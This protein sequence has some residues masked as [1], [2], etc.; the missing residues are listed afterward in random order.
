MRSRARDAAMPIR[1]A[2]FSKKCRGVR[3]H[4]AGD[5]AAKTAV[6]ERD[7]DRERSAR[8]P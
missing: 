7:A 5:I 1:R 6:I 3:P 4:G 8:W 2:G